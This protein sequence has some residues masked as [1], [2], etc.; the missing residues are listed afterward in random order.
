MKNTKRLLPLLLLVLIATQTYSQDYVKLLCK[1]STKWFYEKCPPAKGLTAD[2]T[3][4]GTTQLL[5]SMDTGINGLT[6]RRVVYIDLYDTTDTYLVG[7]LRE[8]TLTR[9]V[10]GLKAFEYNKDTLGDFLLYDFGK[11]IGDTISMIF[12]TYNTPY[13]FEQFIITEIVMGDNQNHTQNRVFKARHITQANYSVKYAEGVGLLG[14]S[15]QSLPHFEGGNY[16]DLICIQQDGKSSYHNKDLD[17]GKDGKEDC[18]Q[19]VPHTGSSIREQAMLQV[20]LSPNPATHSIL[21]DTEK[22]FSY[23]IYSAIGQLVLQGAAQAQEFIS[24]VDL[25]KGF[26]VV[27]VQAGE[28]VGVAKLL[29]E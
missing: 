21:V 9:R 13:T 3:I 25:P 22:V 11:Q 15:Y 24:V 1:Q 29:K 14:I 16:C 17:A 27:Q 2:S 20:K 18:L 23:R 8:D 12:D 6:Y 5:A 4:G 19:R 28:Q 7:F 26:Y 10:Y